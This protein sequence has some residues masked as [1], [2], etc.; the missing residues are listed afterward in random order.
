MTRHSVAGR[1][2]PKCGRHAVSCVDHKYLI[3]DRC[4]FGAF[5]AVAVPSI[6][7]DGSRCSDSAP[8]QDV[9]S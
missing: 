1:T 2:C 5:D 3:C 7:C 6:E 8:G 4:G 9:A